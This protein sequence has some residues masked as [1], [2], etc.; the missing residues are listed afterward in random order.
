[1]GHASI[2][3]KP[4]LVKDNSPPKLLHPGHAYTD[5][6]KQ[7]FSEMEIVILSPIMTAYPLWVKSVVNMTAFSWMHGL[8]VYQMAITQHTVVDWARNELAQMALH[9]DSEYTGRKF[10]HYLWLDADHTFNADLACQL[11]RNFTISDVDMCG[12]VY[13]MARGPTL[14]V[15]YVKDDSP[16]KYKHYPLI[17]VPKS[18]CEV[19]AI[20]F[21]AVLMKR[22]IFERVPKP[23][24]T[25]DANAGEDIAFCVKA[26][27]HGVRI[28][29]DGRYTLGHIGDPPIVG[30]A[31]YNKHMEDN[32][33]MYSDRVKVALGGKKIGKL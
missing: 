27:E 31:D 6:E 17:E 7:I 5:V 14:P 10:S 18:L 2:L 4:T 15:V 9:Y 16:D 12:A 3:K 13:F 33:E 22:N 28:F 26:K 23:W 24:F 19:D 20:G 25:I 8:K 1:M 32:K 21:G 29:C 30:E 11:A